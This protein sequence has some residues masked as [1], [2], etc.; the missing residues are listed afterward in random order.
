M[1]LLAR[2]GSCEEPLLGVLV[3][4]WMGGRVCQFWGSFR[5]QVSRVWIAQ[6]RLF[7][8]PWQ[9]VLLLPLAYYEWPRQVSLSSTMFSFMNILLKFN[10]KGV[11]FLQGFVRVP[12]ENTNNYNIKFVIFQGLSIYNK[13]ISYVISGV[14][15]TLCTYVYIGWLCSDVRLKGERRCAVKSMIVALGAVAAFFSLANSVAAPRLFYL[16]HI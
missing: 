5:A 4:L 1:P 2:P 9:A 11:V 6:C 3:C 16:Q 14:S 12:N 7:A 8:R 15:T 13:Q 10:Y